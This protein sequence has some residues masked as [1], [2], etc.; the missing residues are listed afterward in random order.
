MES[1]KTAYVKIWGDI[2]GAVA[3]DDSQRCAV[4]EFD[5]SF[6]KKGL[7]LAP[8]HMGLDDANRNPLFSFPS[9][10]VHT[11]HGL[12]G[13]LANSLPDRFGNDIID[14]WLRRNGSSPQSFNSV[15]R[16]CYIG[17]RGMGALEFVPEI[18]SKKLSK[19][20]VI[21]IEALMELIR[22]ELAERSK[23]DVHVNEN[24]AD[25]QKA[26]AM[27]DILRV[28]T[29]AG[30]MIPKAIIA[31]NDDGHIISGQSKVPEGYKHW[32]LKFDGISGDDPEKF[33]KSFENGRVEY[34]YYL[35]AKDTGI[36]M[37]DCQLLEENGR[38]RFI[39]RRFDRAGQE[40][41]HVLSLACMGHFG[42]NPA[43]VAG[44]EDAFFTMRSLNLP[45]PEQEQQFR[46]MVFNALAKNT[47]DHTKNISYI[48][49]KDGVWELSP[50]YDVTLSYNPTEPLGDR[51]KMKINGKQK[52]F[53][54]DDFIDVARNMEINNPEKI[55]EQV[56]DSI[57][58]W[59]S[60]AKEAGVN[61]NVATA[62][63]NLHSLS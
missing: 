29:C 56:H 14:S 17:T 18:N 47:D 13:L 6:L 57:G 51:H 2:V 48:M 3:W 7:E 5:T 23:L 53:V 52:D 46:R 41:L 15:E 40:K 21:D 30:G 32:I 58:R 60:F 26:D 12:P 42:W 35:M 59:P 44:Y 25:K 22:E 62:V 38:A 1:V 43:G 39:T 61:K 33:G 49:D 28:G 45:Y 16:L 20:I 19:S 50:A 54:I 8:V 36:D 31:M 4:F 9:I 11:F 24:G 63:G 37:T 34:A 55:I 10:D 27:L